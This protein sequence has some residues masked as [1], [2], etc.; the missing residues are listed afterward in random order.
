[1]FPETNPKKAIFNAEEKN[2]SFT[3]KSKDASI[4]TR[5]IF[6]EDIRTARGPIST[7]FVDLL[8]KVT[9]R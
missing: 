7:A 5:R 6:G 1:M 8:V 9:P 2:C 4:K 3:S